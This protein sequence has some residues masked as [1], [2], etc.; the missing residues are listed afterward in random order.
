MLCGADLIGLFHDDVRKIRAK[1]DADIV[2]AALHDH[3]GPDTMGLWGPTTAETGINETYMTLVVD[4][5]VEAAN[6][7]IRTMRPARLRLAKVRTPELDTFVH[8]TRP[9]VVHDPEIIALQADTLD[10]KPI[11]TLINWAN[12]PETL[13]S[14]NTLVTADY[15]GYLYKEAEKLLGGTTVFINGAVGGM[16][17]PL[18]STIKNVA[19]ATFEKA[20]FI[21]S[22]VAQLAAE[23]LRKTQPAVVDSIAYRET[24]VRIPMPNQGFQMASKA[25]IFAGR[26]PPNPDGTTTTPVGYIRFSRRTQPE[27]EIA[28]VPGELYPELSVGGVEHYPGA[29]FPDAPVE[30]PLKQ[31]L[32]APYR[33]LF[34][35]ANDENGYIIPKS[36]WDEKAPWLQNAPSAGTAKSTRWARTPLRSSPRHSRTWFSVRHPP[37]RRPSCLSRSTAISVRSSRTSAS[38][39]TARMPPTARPKSV[40]ISRAAPAP[41][42]RRSSAASRRWTPPSVCRRPM[43]A[44]TASRIPRSSS[45]AAGWSRAPSGSRSGP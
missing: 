29:D 13:G 24:L 43:R 10:G 45:S 38:P 33:M 28:L 2:I 35:L 6:E 37:W 19:E 23:A 27:L 34:G 31:M 11:A 16:Q 17:S 30:T 9:P 15:P 39:A 32:T 40:S 41:W 18:G 3:E 22:R 26:K 20:E 42:P 5:A 7:A 1:V 12:H 14:K 25:G 21:G 44:V 4:R 8:D 36:E